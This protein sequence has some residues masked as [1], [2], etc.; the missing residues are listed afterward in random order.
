[1]PA[2]N[3]G[4]PT[5]A[6][7][8]KPNLSPRGSMVDCAIR[9]PGAP[10]R[11]RLPPIAAANTK[12]IR[13]LDLFSPDFAAIPMT[14]GMSTAAVPVFESTPLISP[15]I[16]IMATISWHSVL[17]NLVTIPPISLAIPVSNRAPPTMNIATNNITLVSINPPNA[18]F[19]SKTPVTTRPEQTI[20]D[21]SA[22]GIFSDTNITIANAR[23]NKVIIAGLIFASYVL[24]FF[25]HLHYKS[26]IP[27]SIF[28]S[29]W[30]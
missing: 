30:G 12:G 5:M 17:A 23:N 25:L 3:I 18:C 10:I 26:L 28:A 1:M 22:K 4:P 13:S 29:Y 15:T 6:Y 19:T 11:E 14:T 27:K 7:S 8:K 24:N 21:V 16:T 9:F 20:I 2:I